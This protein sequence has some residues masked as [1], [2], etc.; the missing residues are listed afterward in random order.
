[1]AGNTKNLGQVSGLHIGPSAPEN[2]T[3]IWFDN[4]PSQMYHKVYDYGT[5]RWVMLNQQV[6]SVITY[7]ELVNIAKTN[8]LM[9][10]KFYRITDRGNAL[11]I[12]ITT[13]KVQYDDAYG[14][15]LIDDLGTNIQYHVTSSNLRIDDLAGVFDETAK[16]LTFVFKDQAPSPTEGDYLFGKVKRGNAWSLAKYTITSFLS[17]VTGNS[18]TWNGGFYFNFSSAIKDILDKKGGV[19]SKDAYDKQIETITQNITNV[20]KD[21]QSILKAAKDYTDQET[22]PEAFYNTVLDRDLTTG[23]EPIDIAKGDALLSILSKIQR[24]INKF[25]RATGILVSSDFAMT[26]EATPINNNDTV[27]SAL[28]KTMKYLSGSDNIKTSSSTFPVPSSK[29][30]SIVATDSVMTALAKLVYLVNNIDAD[31]LVKNIIGFDEIAKSGVLLTDI[32]RIDLTTSFDFAGGG[33]GGVMVQ[34]YGNFFFTQDDTYP[35][36]PYRLRLFYN[37]AFPKI[38]AFAP[39]I[40]VIPNNT[41]QYSN[42]CGLVHYVEGDATLQAIMQL[43]K[44]TYDSLYSAG[45]RYLK[46]VIQAD[47]YNSLT[48]EQTVYISMNYINILN[49]NVRQSAL[50]KGGQQHIIFKVSVTPTANT[51][52]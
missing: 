28:R 25:K 45:N 41:N 38:L 43:P 47:L 14:N 21:N 1:M 22:A 15:I 7:S 17:V 10:G 48:D 8:G 50:I 44:S 27:D 34:E 29:P 31:Q 46:C 3:L 4:T 5:R 32:F 20:G 12:A 13:T 42:A 51:N 35:Y 18:I 36:N 26:D 6:I 49:I 30:T 16:T 52:S 11:A 40:P 23:G 19:V 39:V 37:S 33:L 9:V 2:T 24:F